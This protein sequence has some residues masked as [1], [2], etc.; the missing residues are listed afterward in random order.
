MFCN[1]NIKLFYIGWFLLSLVVA[2]FVMCQISAETIYLKPVIITSGDPLEAS[3]NCG[4]SCSISGQLLE[5]DRLNFSDQLG[6]FDNFFPLSAIS[7]FNLIINY[8]LEGNT[9][10]E[11]TNPKYS[12]RVKDITISCD[13]KNTTAYSS[14]KSDEKISGVK[15]YLISKE[16]SKYFLCTNPQF[17]FSYKP[18]QKVE[19]GPNEYVKFTTQGKDVV[20]TFNNLSVTLVPNW[21]TK[22]SIFL[23]SFFLSLGAGSIL[24]P[25]LYKINI[26]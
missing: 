2:F 24:Y 1:Q 9:F 21:V 13:G 14:E 23:V 20:V 3:K 4:G 10:L 22:L 17:N 7:R 26:F 12:E 18:T 11:I 8:T 6:G 5:I 15:T 25:Y 16:V 19:V